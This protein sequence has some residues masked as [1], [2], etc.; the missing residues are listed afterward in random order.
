M[1]KKFK[2]FIYKRLI[3]FIRLV[4]IIHW[5]IYL[6]RHAKIYLN[7]GAGRSRYKDWFATDI[8]TLDVTKERDFEKYFGKRKIDKILAEHVLEHLTDQELEKMVKNFYKFTSAGTNIRIAV[9]DGFHIDKNYIERVRPGGFGDGAH[10]HKN[11]F[12]YKSLVD[13]F[14]RHGFKSA[15]REYWDENGNF[16]SNYQ[17]DSDGY[18]ERSLINDDRN[19]DGKP[20]YTSL[21]VDFSKKVK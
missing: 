4:K 12:T 17:N 19:K 10:N 16:Y 15:L 21:I 6:L 8:H 11:L 7:V 9:P 5:N 14:E 2:A 20:N 1:Y 18:I 13:L 3:P